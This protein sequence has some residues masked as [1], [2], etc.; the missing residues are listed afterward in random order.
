MNTSTL[1]F[2]PKRII[3]GCLFLIICNVNYAQKSDTTNTA[4]KKWSININGGSTQFWGYINSWNL[5]TTLKHEPTWGY[6]LIMTRQFTHL[7]GIRG[8]FLMGKL[9]GRKELF[10]DGTPANLSYF[11]DFIEGNISAKI[12]LTDII[13]GYKPNRRFNVYGI[14]GIGMSNFQGETTNFI[15]KVIVNSYGH[16][17]GRGINGYELEGLGNVGIGLAIKLNKV[18]DFTFENSMKFIQT[19]KLNEKNGSFPFDLYGYSS[20]GLTYN[21]R[22]NKGQ[23][24]K[25]VSNNINQEQPKSVTTEKKPAEAKKDIV[26]TKTEPK[27][28]QEK[29]EIKK[30]TISNPI[31]EKAEQKGAPAE[32][33][34][35][36]I[37]F[38]GYKVQILATLAPTPFDTIMQQFNLNEQIRED[39]IDKWYRYSVGEFQSFKEA[40]AYRKLLYT[41]NHIKDSFITKFKDGKRIGQVWK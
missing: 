18:L 19:N 8:Q 2:T 25:P 21:F 14:A 38:S 12:N 34:V 36:A 29:P 13:R 3:L 22:S 35:K 28:T 9:K 23:K 16:K 15:T 31:P 20:F 39:H 4:F 41:R 37:L 1:I 26:S 32:P 11:S 5:A 7:F 30:E 6:G 33:I 17:K 27:A 40:N 10:S 24:S